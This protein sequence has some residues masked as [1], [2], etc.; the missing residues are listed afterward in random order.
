MKEKLFRID[1]VIS[2]SMT[3]CKL[4]HIHLLMP[5]THWSVWKQV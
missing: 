4:N 1:S 2:R 3:E 5:C